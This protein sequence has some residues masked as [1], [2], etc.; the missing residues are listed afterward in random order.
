[1]KVGSFVVD[2]HPE[3][4]MSPFSHWDFVW[5]SMGLVGLLC[6]IG[7][8]HIRRRNRDLGGL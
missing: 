5:S 2:I 8:W 1:M 3:A 4:D 6:H 7:G